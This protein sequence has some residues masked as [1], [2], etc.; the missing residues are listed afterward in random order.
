MNK[1]LLSL[2]SVMCLFG[3]IAVISAQNAP[4]TPSVVNG[5]EVKPNQLE[6]DSEELLRSMIRDSGGSEEG[7]IR[8]FEEYLGTFP[9]SLRRLEI[10]DQIYQLA[11]KSRDRDRTISYGE[12]L[13]TNPAAETSRIDLLTTLVS[14]LRSRRGQGDL[15]RAL[16]HAENLVNE[17]EQLISSSR[18]PA[19]LSRLQWQEQ[20]DQ[21]L[22]SVY[23]VRGRVLA[24]LDQLE[25]AESDLRRSYHLHPLAG[26]ALSLSEINE[27]QQRSEEALKFA[28]MAFVLAHSGEEQLDRGAIRQRMGK[29]YLA[30]NRSEKGLGDLLLEAWDKYS[31]DRDAKLARLDP[32]NPNDGVMDPLLFRLTR[33][34]GS[35]L[36]MQTLKGKVIVLNFWATWC[37]PCRTELPLFQKTMEKY[38]TDP[39]VAFLA[40]ST[41]EDRELVQPY[42]NNNDYKLPVVFADR[43]D[44]HFSVSSIPTTIILNPRGE[45]VFRMRGFNPNEDFLVRLSEKIEAARR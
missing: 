35:T 43:I 4:I 36:E 44:E 22:A 25:R 40:I 41:D 13:I 30:K 1:V 17:F 2:Y 29:L 20:K 9:R 11:I 15:L 33:T 19:R 10:E 8:K 26:A 27:K 6:T 3:L 23:L 28:T 5:A 42:L 7:L 34:N 12:R 39:G 16:R 38:Q 32:P 18:K 24:E 37:G 31:K 14:T 45:V 21:G